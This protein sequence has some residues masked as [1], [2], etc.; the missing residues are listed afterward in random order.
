MITLVVNALEGVRAWFIL[1]GF[2]VIVM[3]QD[4]KG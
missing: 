1:F 4:S 2:N 3:V